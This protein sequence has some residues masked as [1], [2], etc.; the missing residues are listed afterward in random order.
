MILTGFQR[1][2]DVILHLWWRITSCR[3]NTQFRPIF[4][5]IIKI[6]TFFGSLLKCDFRFYRK[7]TASTSR[8]LSVRFFA[9]MSS[10]TF[11]A[12][13]CGISSFLNVFKAKHTGYLNSSVSRARRPSR[14]PIGFLWKI[15]FLNRFINY[16][17]K[18]E[19]ICLKGV[20]RSRSAL[21]GPTDLWYKNSR[22]VHFSGNYFS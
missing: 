18:F 10:F 16:F 21:V 8:L 22:N 4:I 12:K 11:C 5:K 19:K 6:W 9:N 15:L 13:K 7:R 2:D 17:E 3:K 14:F 1:F 20:C